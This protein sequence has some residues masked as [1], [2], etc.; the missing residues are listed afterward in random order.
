MAR[1]LIRTQNVYMFNA[2]KIFRSANKTNTIPNI[3]PKIPLIQKISL[4]RVYFR[5]LTQ[6]ELKCFRK[7][8]YLFENK[9]LPNVG[10][11]Y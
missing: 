9:Y 10:T 3:I 7:K 11:M 6:N 1:A 5:L 2:V 8:Y 4:A